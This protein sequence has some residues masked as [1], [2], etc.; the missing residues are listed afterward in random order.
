MSGRKLPDPV[1]TALEAGYDDAAKAVTQLTSSFE[2]D[3]FCRRYNANDGFEPLHAAVCHPE[4]DAG[5]ALF[6]YWQFHELLDD[7]QERTATRA[8]PARWNADALLAQIE[9][10][11]PHAYRHQ[12]I[13]C[14]PVRD[15]GLDPAYV[16]RIR[17]R[18]PGA[19]LMQPWL[20]PGM[21]HAPLPSPGP[22][23]T[24]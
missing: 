24:P 8:E 1:Q 2:L 14:G 13:A 10:R 17:A 12:R 19:P 5:T 9:Q 18:H 3:Q 23:K 7:T 4:C 21:S 20:A 22:R 6:V 11:F 15:M 16:G